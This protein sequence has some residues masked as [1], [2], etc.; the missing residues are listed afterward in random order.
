[1][2]KISFFGGRI[3]PLVGL[4]ISSSS[5]KL[6]ELSGDPVSGLRIEAYAIEL[7]ANDMVQ[8]GNIVDLEGV[9][10]AARRAL[11]RVPGVRNVA[12]ALP[13]SAVITKRI[14]LPAGLREH[15]MEFHVEAEAHQFVPFPLDEVNI[16]FQE[17]GPSPASPE[18]VEVFVAASRKERVE[19]CV[20]VAES[21]GLIA[22]V[23][24]I[25]SLA[26][27]SAFGLMARHFPGGMEDKTIVLADVG[28][29]TL[30]VLVLRNGHQI[31]AREQAIGGNR[32]TQDIARQYGMSFE[33]A[34][35]AKRSGDLPVEYDQELRR[36]FLESVALE[37]S[38]ALQFFFTSTPYDQVDHIVLSGGCAVMP[39]L[40]EAIAARTQFSASVANPFVGMTLS[41]RVRKPHLAADAPALMVAC[42]L[43]MRRFDA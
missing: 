17:L 14:M 26:L 3:R 22:T 18:D 24:D 4:E 28:A 16:D 19:D 39:D 33:E 36:L 13:P 5:V 41:P 1:M 34:E 38:R 32:L 2:R 29:N 25:E 31:Y 21:A 20:A 40:A 27:E 9:S 10:E 43:A 35:N 12:M 11:R 30:N 42:G 8:D 7:L 15:E 6:V 23:I 37:V